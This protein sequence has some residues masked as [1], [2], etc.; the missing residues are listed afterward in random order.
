MRLILITDV[1]RVFMT[2]S[3]ELTWRGFKNQTTL[4]DIAAL[5]KGKI[6]FY[7]GAD[8]SAPS[9]TVGNLAM[10]M[11]VRHFITAGHK[12]VLLVGG[13]YGYDWRPRW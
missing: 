9:M 7:W 8:P 3:E 4:N 12:A 11:M 1:K 5:D 13:G 10:A 2:L 6:T